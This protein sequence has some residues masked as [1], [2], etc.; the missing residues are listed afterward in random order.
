LL[1]WY[2]DW[3]FR[4]GSA[5][6]LGVSRA[7]FYLCYCWQLWVLHPL[8]YVVVPQQFWSAVPLLDWLPQPAPGLAELVYGLTFLSGCLAILGW[9]TKWTTACLAVLGTWVFSWINS[10]GGI[11][12]HTMP[13]VLISWILPFSSCG[14][15]FSLDS[16]GR[17]LVDDSPAY[18]WPIRVCW[19]PLLLPM[20]SAGVH[21]VVGQW[22]TQPDEMIESFLRYK[23]YVHGSTKMLEISPVVLKLLPYRGLLKCAAYL[24]VALELGCPLALL[25]RPVFLRVFWVGGLFVMQLTLAYAL[26]TLETFPWMGA[27]VFWVP[28]EKFFPNEVRA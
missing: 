4:A 27:Y 10:L 18:N 22:L 20:A 6:R 21:K 7:L 28:W 15:A 5:R 17:E 9:R 2:S 25:D 24:T 12:F 19:F 26:I 13:L 14:D 8:D 11:S 16:R 3:M 1:T 23:Y